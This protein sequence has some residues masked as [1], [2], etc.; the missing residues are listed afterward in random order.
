MS[1]LT[2]SKDH[3]YI[4]R[5]AL[6]AIAGL[7][8]QMIVS[9]V[10]TALVGRLPD[11]EY[12]LAAMGIG[13]LATWAVVS[14]F[15]SL[16]TGTHVL[17]ARRY[18]EN[19]YEDCGKVLNTSIMLTFLIGLAVSLLVVTS[20]HWIASF[21]AADDKVGFYAG[22]FLYYRFMGI[23]FFLIT[24]SYRGFFFGIGNTKIF[25]ISGILVNLLNII[26]NI[27]L[28]YGAFGIKGMGLAG[29][30]LGSTLATICDAAFY[31][32]VSLLPAYRKKFHYFKNLK[33]VKEIASSIINIS[34]PVSL[35]NI[36]ILVG[37]LSFISITGLIG[38]VEQAASNVVFSSL[39]ISLLPCFGFGIAVHTLVGNSIGSGDIQKAKFLG[40]ET[41]KLA[42]I[43]TIAVGLLFVTVPRLV[44]AITTN[45]QNV[46]ETA[47]PA[48]RIAGLGQ[49]FYGIG[50]V[51]ANGLQ[52]SG[53]TFFVMLAEVIVNWFIFVPIAYF[54]G[55]FLKL[56]VIGAWFA[57]PFYVIIY[58]VVIFVKFKFGDWTKYKKV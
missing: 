51:L 50:V 13:V 1:L 43:Y 30:G 55:V 57:L 54:L 7:S 11:T 49:I 15:S 32:G 40:F 18:G 14:L 6:P 10:D 19:K 29:S 45:D 26:F 31:F 53:A 35:Q 48:L 36:F 41:S 4:L 34:L 56:G 22:E 9:L 21:F 39:L 46:I 52:A 17:I 42:T 23:P 16:A 58:A 38:T 27:I 20:S 8:T 44:L 5:I 47:V 37:F 2:L 28:I 3:K 25:M 33:F 24:V 12:V